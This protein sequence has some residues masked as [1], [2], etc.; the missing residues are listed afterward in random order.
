[1]DA[2]GGALISTSILFAVFVADAHQDQRQVA[3]ESIG[4]AVIGGVRLAQDGMYL[5]HVQGDGTLATIHA[6]ARRFGDLPAVATAAPYWAGG[7]GVSGWA[8]GP[9]PGHRGGL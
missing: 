4:G 5:I 3:V 1:M 9:P 6:I 7:L 2:G 8:D